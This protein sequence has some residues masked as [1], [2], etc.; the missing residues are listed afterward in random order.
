MAPSLRGD[1]GEDKAVVLG[2]GRPYACIGLFEGKAG[3]GI[4]EGFVVARVLSPSKNRSTLSTSS[5]TESIHVEFGIIPWEG[6]VILPRFEFKN[7]DDCQI[8]DKLVPRDVI[9]HRTCPRHGGGK[10]E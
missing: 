9:L 7:D 3:A 4:V 8:I 5:S 2:S 6:A 1:G 10:A